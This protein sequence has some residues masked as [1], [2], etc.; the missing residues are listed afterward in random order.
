MSFLPFLLLVSF[1][2]L[3]QIESLVGQQWPWDISDHRPINEFQTSYV[4][5]HSVTGRSTSNKKFWTGY[6]KKMNAARRRDVSELKSVPTDYIGKRDLGSVQTD[7]GS[8][9]GA[10]KKVAR[11]GNKKDRAMKTDSVE[12]N[13]HQES[14]NVDLNSIQTNKVDDSDSKEND[15]VQAQHGSTE[16]G[17]ISSENNGGEVQGF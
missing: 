2:N 11:I 7:Y 15:S 9:D 17:N 5:R 10:P 12:T 4:S 3:R 16:N 1:F 13:E 6:M 14:G 8:V